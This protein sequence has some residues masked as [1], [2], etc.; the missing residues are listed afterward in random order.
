[1]NEPQHADGDFD[2]SAIISNLRLGKDRLVERRRQA[3]ETQARIAVEIEQIDADLARIERMLPD[4][5]VKSAAP[6]APDQ[7]RRPRQ[8]GLHLL[9]EEQVRT[10]DPNKEFTLDAIIACVTVASPDAREPDRSS[11]RSVLGKLVEQGA[12]IRVS[13]AGGRNQSYLASRGPALGRAP[14]PSADAKAEAGPP[15]SLPPTVDGVREQVVALLKTAGDDGMTRADLA[16]RMNDASLLD[17]ALADPR[18]VEVAAS[19][20]TFKLKLE[21]AEM[22]A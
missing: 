11:V 12:L 16:W 7:S 6:A 15:L 1:M 5:P 18:I 19:P 8:A 10:M 13:K 14:T 21:Q 22:F 20:G 9:V 3:V 4:D 17:D 2:L